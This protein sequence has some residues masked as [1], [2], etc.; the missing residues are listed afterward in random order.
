MTLIRA[1]APPTAR[2]GRR[3]DQ[4]ARARAR[5][6]LA[7]YGFI[8]P[9]FVVFIPFG[10]GAVVFAIGMAFVKWPIGGSPTFTGV[11]NFT[12]IKGDPIFRTA[13]WNTTW[14]LFA[15]LII[16]LP[17][18]LAVATA[19][20]RP[21]LHLRRSM[22]MV[23]FLPITASLVVV[24]VVFDLLYDDN[25]GFLNNALSHVGIPRI[26]F[27]TDP[28]IAPWAIIA[29]RVWRVVG[30]YAVI[31]YAGMQDISPELYEAAALDG[32]GPWRQFTAVTLPLLRPITL[33]VA[34]AAS[35]GGW[36]LFA[37]PQILTGGGPARATITAVMYVYQTSFL[38]FQLG[39]GA[40]AAVVLAVCIIA[41]TVVFQ[42]VLRSRTS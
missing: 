9:F 37:E 36:E 2:H 4:A 40:A 17:L 22:Q 7:P 39:Q 11:D 15:Y 31:L 41:T 30:Y 34:V 14:M 23:F 8:L 25:V 6:R 19:L 21:R 3:G 13:L 12:A 5:G 16:L 1:G 20:S 18:A 28:H 38:N 32:A 26:H 27:L 33:F 42:R 29:L 35:I 24:A 10:V